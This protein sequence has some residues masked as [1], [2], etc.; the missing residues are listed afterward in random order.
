MSKC[1]HCQ[2]PIDAAQPLL[3]RCPHCLCALGSEKEPSPSS[4]GSATV[5]LGPAATIDLSPADAINI[6]ADFGNL[7]TVNLA[8]STTAMAVKQRVPP[9]F[10][11]SPLDG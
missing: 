4:V 1:P 8:N 6:T 9:S 10:C 7:R 5:S 3:E 11:S 2:T